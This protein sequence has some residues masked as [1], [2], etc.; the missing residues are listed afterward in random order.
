MKLGVESNMVTLRSGA[1]SRCYIIQIVNPAEE[2]TVFEYN[3]RPEL[4]LEDTSDIDDSIVAHGTNAT[5]VVARNNKGKVEVICGSRRRASTIKG[6]KPLTALVIEDVSDNDAK[7][8]AV[9]EN[10]G[11]K[12]FDIFTQVAEWEMLLE[13]PNPAFKSVQQLATIYEKKDR[14]YI[15]RNRIIKNI[16]KEVYLN[17]TDRQNVKM[18]HAFDAAT[19][20]DKLPLN[21][22]GALIEIYSGDNKET[23]FT[24]FAAD[25]KKAYEEDISQNVGENETKTKV[26]AKKLGTTTVVEQYERAYLTSNRSQKAVVFALPDNVDFNSVDIKE[27]NDKLEALFAAHLSQ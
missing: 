12:G 9:S 20:L 1:R 5:P 18:K 10:Q 27:V 8:I 17:F 25:V 22:K 11:R 4:D 3:L 7:Y 15:S 19:M 21:R 23:T 6:N 26:Q 13:G 16:P 14:T 2:T 24:D